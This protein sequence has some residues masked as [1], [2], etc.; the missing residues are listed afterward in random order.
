MIHILP[1]AYL[2]YPRP[3]KSNYR[4]S[5]VAL[6]KPNQGRAR[7][8]SSFALTLSSSLTRS[9]SPRLASPR[10]ASVPLLTPFL[11]FFSYPLTSLPF[12]MSSLLVSSILLSIASVIPAEGSPLGQP[13]AKRQFANAST[14]A[15][16]PTSSKA[17]RTLCFPCPEIFPMDFP[18]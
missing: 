4:S 13:L 14:K 18:N 15:A 6:K 3:Q 17:D 11:S 2:Y 9:A 10:L 5:F 7:F 8:F 12:A 16:D 1:L